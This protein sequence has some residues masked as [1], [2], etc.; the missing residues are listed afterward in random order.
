MPSPDIK[1]KDVMSARVVI[2]G[3]STD[4]ATAAKKMKQEDVGS[5]VVVEGNRPVG[6][7]TREDIVNKVVAAGKA[8]SKVSAREIMTTPV[9]TASP[10]EDL[11]DVA[12]RMNKYGYERMPVKELNKLT[13]FITVRDILRVSPGMLELLKEHMESEQAQEYAE[14]FN[15]GECELCG[16]F[17][18]QLRNM[19]DRW[20]CDTCAE[21][22]TEV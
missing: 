13:G 12:E 14:E 10:D 5:I 2:C 6:M 4:V 15:A 9:V 8:A 11:I 18:E 16:N 3:P 1:V 22:A 7:V 21:E 20:V 17:S 19:N